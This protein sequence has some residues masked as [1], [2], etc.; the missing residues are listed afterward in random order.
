MK[1][2]TRFN[3]THHHALV[4]VWQQAYHGASSTAWL[5]FSIVFFRPQVSSNFYLSLSRRM[6][7]LVRIANDRL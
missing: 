5:M 6:F 7:A 1:K 2:R 4:L 3:G